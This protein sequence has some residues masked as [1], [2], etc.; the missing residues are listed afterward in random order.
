MSSLEIAIAVAMLVGLVGTVLP[1]IPGLGLIMGAGLVWALV[2]G[3]GALG[4]VVAI[5]MVVVGVAGMAIANALPA[6]RTAAAGAPWWIL[7]V[8]AVGVVVGFFLVPIV[9]ALLGGP[10]AV[11]V[12]ELIRLRRLGPAWRSTAE[13]LKGQAVGIGVQLVAGVVMISLWAIAVLAV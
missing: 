4:W 6:R 7:A 12:A 2:G 11:F 10:V 9:G 8:G 13:A 3:Q 1:I 5:V